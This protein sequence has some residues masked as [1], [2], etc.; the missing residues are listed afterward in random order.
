MSEQLLAVC[1]SSRITI[2]YISL[3]VVEDAPKGGA[4]KIDVQLVGS[5]A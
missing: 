2:R 5:A 3:I 1:E 4:S